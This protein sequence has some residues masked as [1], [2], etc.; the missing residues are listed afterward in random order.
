LGSGKTTS[1]DI[2]HL[3][4]VSQATVS[5]A[6]RNSPLV[7]EA[8]REKVQR[9]A[10][11]LNYQVDRNAASLR[12]QES[13]TLALLLFEDRVSDGTQINPFFLSMLG[14]ITRAAA[15]RQY[16]VLVSFQQLSEDWHYEY[17]VS[18]R[19]DGLILLGY[20]DYVSFTD[21]LARL[22]EA[23]ARFVMWGATEP[24]LE[25]HAVGCENAQ[26]G[27]IATRH[28]LKL[29]RR[30][31]AFLG[32]VSDGS[33]EFKR[34]HAGYLRALKA[35]GIEADPG[36]QFDAVTSEA[37][38]MEAMARMLDSGQSFDAVFAASDLIAVGAIRQ[39][40]KSGLAVPEDIAV[41]GFDD[42][43]GASFLTP[44]LTTVRQDT[45]RAAEVLVD[46]LLRTIK[47]E[48]VDSVLIP[49]SLVVRGS[50]G[51]REP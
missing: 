29:G 38:G 20:G 19:A 34:R 37:A 8:T 47:G 42:I 51:G 48:S 28:L 39:L 27:E 14:H 49:P 26:G 10:R 36:L 5:R 45:K 23:G 22:L 44:S 31:I 7:S 13:R 43:P 25:G 16:D 1:F 17:E 6:L 2:A 18:N 32:G 24:G 46:R 40:H 9:I 4:G 21:K 15:R 11:E 3:A 35:A 41:V 33:P 50:C 30:R 12:S